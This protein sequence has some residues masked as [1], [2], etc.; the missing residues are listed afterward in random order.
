MFYTGW[1]L[2]KRSIVPADQ[3]GR[4][5]EL[6]LI[7]GSWMIASKGLAKESNVYQKQQGLPAHLFS[8]HSRIS[9]EMQHLKGNMG[10]R[11]LLVYNIFLAAKNISQTKRHGQV[12]WLPEDFRSIAAWPLSSS[13]V[14]EVSFSSRCILLNI[15]RVTIVWELILSLYGWEAHCCN[16]LSV[17][18]YVSNW[19]NQKAVLWWWNRSAWVK[20]DCFQALGY[21]YL[22]HSDFVIILLAICLKMGISF[23]CI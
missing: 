1:M 15:Q 4:G 17:L 6:C 7:S 18:K 8:C 23:M 3:N 10:E 12:G 2:G 21:I 19:N 22:T 11:G 16:R 20:C 9:A 13:G 14:L 5:L